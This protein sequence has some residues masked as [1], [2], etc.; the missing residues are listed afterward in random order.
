LRKFPDGLESLQLTSMTHDASPGKADRRSSL[1]A[2]IFDMDGLMIDSESA[3][4]EAGRQI[5]RSFGKEVTKKTLGNMMGRRPIESMEIFAADL[6]LSVSPQELLERRDTEVFETLR[7][8]VKPMPGLLATLDA[9]RGTYCLAIATSATRKFLD[10]VITQLGIA[11][12]FEALQTS[13]NVSQGK[14]DPEIYLKAMAKLNL[15]GEACAVFEDST[16]GALAGKRAGAYTVAVPSEYTNWQDFSFVDYVAKNLED[17][18]SHL[19]L[20]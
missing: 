6:G 14:P 8:G 15:P 16:N 10:L 20:V 3:Y 1:R 19:G 13:D 7:R 4:W 11:S 17:A 12:R 9:L 5:A 2:V 18:A